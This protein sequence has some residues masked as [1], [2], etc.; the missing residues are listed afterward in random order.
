MIQ[1][2]EAKIA[3]LQSKLQILIKTIP[4]L[5]RE[6]E[7]IQANCDRI[8]ARLNALRDEIAANQA[9]YKILTEEIRVQNG[10]IKDREDEIDRL[11]DAIKNLPSELI[12]LQ[13]ELARIL[14]ALR[15]QYYICND[16]V[17][18]VKK[19][20]IA[21]DA[22]VLK[23]N[24]ESQY[25]LEANTNLEAARSEKEVADLAVEEIIRSTTDATLFPIVPNGQGET[26]PGL[27]AGNN[28][29]GSALGEVSEDV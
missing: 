5:E 16:K 12:V 21:L 10:L 24:T 1:E 22:M 26:D 25:L 3:V 28:P 18:I 15:R 29:S 20:K 2:A 4:S 7:A 17:E 14:N 23:Y 19:A 9:D 27:P 6:I 11:Q 8:L 13:N